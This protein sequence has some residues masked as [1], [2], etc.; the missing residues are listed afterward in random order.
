MLIQHFWS[1]EIQRVPSNNPGQCIG[2]HILNF[3]HAGLTVWFCMGTIIIKQILLE[4]L[5]RYTTV[6]SEQ[7]MTARPSL[8]TAKLIGWASKDTLSPLQV[9]VQVAQ[10][11]GTWKSIT[12][13]MEYRCFETPITNEIVVLLKVRIV[14]VFVLFSRSHSKRII[15]TDGVQIRSTNS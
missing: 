2:Y 8:P 13:C 10:K 3:S 11:H 15:H 14:P 9:N 1:R 4:L 7:T 5:Y 6:W 12:G